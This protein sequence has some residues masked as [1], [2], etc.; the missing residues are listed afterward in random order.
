MCVSKA[1]SCK[2][3]WQG[4]LTVL[5]I[6]I[7]GFLGGCLSLLLLHFFLILLKVRLCKPEELVLFLRASVQLSG[8]LGILLRGT[9]ASNMEKG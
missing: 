6:L 5:L 1:I 8:D 9:T 3:E 7:V 2:S 4:V